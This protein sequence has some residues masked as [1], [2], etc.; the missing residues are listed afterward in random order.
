MNNNQTLYLVSTPI[1]NY[2]DITLRALNILKSVD[3]IICE[4]IKEA[5][6]LLSNYQIEKPLLQINEH[7]EKE[8]TPEIIKELKS[9]KIAALISDCGTP[10]FSD[11]GLYLVNQ[12]LEAKIKIVPIPGANSV[13]QALS[14][15]GL[16]LDNFYFYG[17][18]PAKTELRRQEL[19]RLKNMHELIIFME[20]PYR[21]KKIVGDIVQYFGPNTYC[22]LAFE[23][24]TAN[25]TFYRGSAKDIYQMAEEKNL[26]GEFVLL[27]EKRLKKRSNYK[28]K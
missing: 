4:E 18:L 25:E 24:T 26:K 13:I 23:L 2:E 1:G 10:I 16:N 21:L 3:F 14:G 9:G 5:R 22:I 17:W 12:C 20:T 6:R 7:N 15:A 28:N 19:L 8:N 11:P 27:V